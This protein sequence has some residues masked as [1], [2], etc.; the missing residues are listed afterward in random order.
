MPT[1]RENVTRIMGMLEE[2]F[3]TTL[4]ARGRIYLP[5]E[6]RDRLSIKESDKIYIKIERNHLILYTAKMIE[7]ELRRTP[8]VFP[9]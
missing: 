7:K 8:S 2:F 9:A 4:D 1:K 6:V 3:K 5:R